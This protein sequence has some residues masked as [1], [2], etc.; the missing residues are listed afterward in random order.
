MTLTSK[1]GYFFVHC[2]KPWG[3]VAG[4]LY[5][6]VISGKY[7]FMTL[8]NVDPRICVTLPM[9]HVFTGCGTACLIIC[10]GGKKIASLSH[11]R[12]SIKDQWNGKGKLSC[13]YM[14]AFS[15]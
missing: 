15:W 10:T 2:D 3:I 9:F 14:V 7:P 5:L 13:C 1:T 6:D 8:V 11:H 12:V 4:L